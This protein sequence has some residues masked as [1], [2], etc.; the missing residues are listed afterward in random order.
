MKRKL[1]SCIIL[2][3][4]CIFEVSCKKVL[5]SIINCTGESVFMS[6][7]YTVDASS[8]K[9]VHFEGKYSGSHSFDS[10]TWDFGDGKTGTG[11]TVDH[12]YAASGTYNVK[13][14]IKVTDGKSH[15]ESDPVRSVVIN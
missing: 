9:L 1:L 3:S 12:T 15:C 13:A 14:K 2:G 5:E 10:V 8:P 7:H 6:L 11:K 4:V